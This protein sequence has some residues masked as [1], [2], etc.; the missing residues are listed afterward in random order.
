MAN[1]A[2]CT[3]AKASP[4]LIP[5]PFRERL[6]DSVGGFAAFFNHERHQEPG[7]MSAGCFSKFRHFTSCRQDGSMLYHL[8]ELHCR[9]ATEPV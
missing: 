5:D 4:E 9:N 8:R 3:T 6:K 1:L 2:K 7:E